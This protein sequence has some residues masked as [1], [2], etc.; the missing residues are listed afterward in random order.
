MNSDEFLIGLDPIESGLLN[1][2]N[3]GLFRGTDSVSA[4][5]AELYKL[6]VYGMLSEDDLHT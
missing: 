2:V 3:G 4:I 5:R 1:A 6:N